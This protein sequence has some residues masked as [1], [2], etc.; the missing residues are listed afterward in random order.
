MRGRHHVAHRVSDLWNS[1]RCISQESGLSDHFSLSLSRERE[2]ELENARV[3][4]HRGES[5]C[6]LRAFMSARLHCAPMRITKKFAGATLGKSIFYRT[7]HLDESD[8]WRLRRLETLFVRSEETTSAEAAF[9]SLRETQAGRTAAAAAAVTGQAA[10][11]SAAAAASCAPTAFATDRER[12]GSSDVVTG[13]TAFASCAASCAAASQAR[14]TQEDA[15]L[16]LRRS[17]R[18]A[19]SERRAAALRS[20]GECSDEAGEEEGE[21]CSQSR[22]ARSESREDEDSVLQAREASNLHKRRRVGSHEDDPMPQSASPTFAHDMP[23]VQGRPVAIT[24]SKLAT[25]V[26]SASSNAPRLARGRRLDSRGSRYIRG[27]YPSG[28]FWPQQ[29]VETLGVW[30]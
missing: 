3:S 26:A 30:A 22:G 11:S 27:D 9:F 21:E 20:S 28:L 14:A 15:V 8:R 16:H 5:V 12:A 29:R 19:P 2:S 17:R 7:G 4:T 25:G 18:V 6:R 10:A 24:L 1:A 23:H 13:F